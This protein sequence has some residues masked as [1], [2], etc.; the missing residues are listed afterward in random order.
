MRVGTYGFEKLSPHDTATREPTLRFLGERRESDKPRG[1]ID[2]EQ[3]ADIA[4]TA[5]TTLESLQLGGAM[6]RT[7][8][9]N[10]NGVYILECE[11]VPSE[12]E[13]C[14]ALRLRVHRDCGQ[15]RD[16]AQ[17]GTGRMARGMDMRGY[18]NILC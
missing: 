1:K 3:I 6:S 4:P 14:Q 12:E 18:R 7:L 16:R 15:L 11:Q 17:H 5:P 8:F 13:I 9:G 10:L 2:V